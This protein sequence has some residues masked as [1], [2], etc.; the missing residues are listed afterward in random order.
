MGSH[1]YKTWSLTLREERR[2]RM[3]DNRMLRIIFG[4]KRDEVTGNGENYLM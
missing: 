1:P 3:L 4:P 2:L